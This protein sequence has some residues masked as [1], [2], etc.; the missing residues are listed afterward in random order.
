M[1]WG[2]ASPKWTALPWADPSP[3]EWNML[4]ARIHPRL[5]TSPCSVK[6]SLPPAEDFQLSPENQCQQVI[7]KSACGHSLLSKHGCSFGWLQLLFERRGW[8]PLS[9]IPAEGVPSPADSETM[10]GRLQ[11]LQSC[12]AGLVHCG[13][14]KWPHCSSERTMQPLSSNL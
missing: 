3:C 5:L 13:L 6:T 12:S 2:Q 8:A 4:R 1:Q 10:M 9:C 14:S 11:A 7:W